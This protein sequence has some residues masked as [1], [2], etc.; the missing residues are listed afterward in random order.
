MEL[1]IK[2]EKIKVMFNLFIEDKTI[3]TGDSLL[4]DFSDVGK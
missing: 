3:M 1:K 2:K 4:E